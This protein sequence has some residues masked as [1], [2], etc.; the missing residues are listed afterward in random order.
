L[1]VFVDSL[2]ERDVVVVVVVNVSLDDFRDDVLTDTLDDNGDGGVLELSLIEFILLLCK[3]FDKL[4]KE[5]LLLYS[6]WVYYPP[7]FFVHIFFFLI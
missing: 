5:L 4:L 3:E 6:K 7:F 1:S 2:F